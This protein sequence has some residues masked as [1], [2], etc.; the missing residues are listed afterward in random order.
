MP[1]QPT[2]VIGAYGPDWFPLTDAAIRKTGAQGTSFWDPDGGEPPHPRYVLQAIDEQAQGA[3]IFA[4]MAGENSEEFRDAFASVLNPDAL[5]FL[6]R[7]VLVVGGLVNDDYA[8]LFDEGV[9]WVVGADAEYVL[10]TTESSR[11]YLEA[12]ERKVLSDIH[13]VADD[14]SDLDE[15]LTRLVAGAPV[16]VPVHEL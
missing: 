10:L 8:Y 4:D 9:R 15:I 16:P 6:T 3:R 2:L 11:R 7:P 5:P 14:L 13:V 12:L 1:A